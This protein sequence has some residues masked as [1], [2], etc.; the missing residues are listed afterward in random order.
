M[1]AGALGM[2]PHLLDEGVRGKESVVLLR[3]LLDQVLVLV[4]LL[5]VLHR[6]V[7]EPDLLRLF[8]PNPPGRQ[9]STTV[10]WTR[11]YHN[12]I[13]QGSRR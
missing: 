11:R 5:Q 3:E 12:G 4:E 2:I 13:W 7:V 8:L 1:Y 10:T 6:H 9:H